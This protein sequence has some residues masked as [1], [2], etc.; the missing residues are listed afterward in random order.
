MCFINES[1][2]DI[3]EQIKKYNLANKDSN[4]DYNVTCDVIK[5]RLKRKDERKGI[6]KKEMDFY[7][8]IFLANFDWLVQ[9]SGIKTFQP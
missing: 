8:V 2:S 7:D 1:I 4:E 9:T 5:I 6:A 3:K